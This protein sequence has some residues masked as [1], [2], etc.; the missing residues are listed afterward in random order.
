[1]AKAYKPSDPLPEPRIQTD[2]DFDAFIKSC[3][4]DD[5]WDIAHDEKGIKVWDQK[6]PNSVI[7]AVKVR[8]I[9]KDIDP[10]VLYDVFHDAEYRREW[11]ENMID[12]QEFE[13]LDKN[14]DIGYY[15][16]KVPNPMSNRDFVN[17]RAWRIKGNQYV[18]KNHSVN[19]PK[20]PEKKNFT[21]ARSISTGYY[22]LALEG[23]GCQLIYLTQS[24]PKG[25]IPNMISNV[26]TKKLA[27]KIVGK[28]E[29]AAKKYPKWKA[30]HN[31]DK[32]PWRD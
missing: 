27:P 10:A 6:I 28:I 12:G 20:C 16:V 14:N 23:G 8:T 7:N 11:D 1:M 18:I 9:F 29:E 15:S 21:R 32:H 26:V 22:I 4:E 5:G 25:A 2:E 24:D 30:E 19:Y 17:Q 3:E 13:E 31:P